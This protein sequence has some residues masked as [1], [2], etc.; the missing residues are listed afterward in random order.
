MA[1]HGMAWYVCFVCLSV[2]MYVCLYVCMYVMYVCR[3]ICM[4]V[5]MYV[6][7]YICTFVWSD[8]CMYVCNYCMYVYI[9]RD[10]IVES[11]QREPSIPQQWTQRSLGG[12]CETWA[13]SMNRWQVVKQC[14]LKNDWTIRPFIT[15][16]DQFCFYK[17][18][19]IYRPFFGIH[20]SDSE[21]YPLPPV[22]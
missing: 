13:T 4:F 20:D 7:L 3:Y 18:I 21:I 6:C 9:H 2:C 8:G 5:C 11:F 1:W 12:F 15:I 10:S 19:F 16:Y 14:I 17:Y 22:L